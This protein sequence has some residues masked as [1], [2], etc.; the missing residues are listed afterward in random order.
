MMLGSIIQSIGLILDIVGVLMIADFL[1]K[2]EY[3]DSSPYGTSTNTS[4]LLT[5]LA[6]APR[7]G[8]Y[9]LITG[10]IVQLVGVWL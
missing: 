6:N 1:R 2:K 9:F 3:Y 8:T 7:R 4:E 10:F 5:N